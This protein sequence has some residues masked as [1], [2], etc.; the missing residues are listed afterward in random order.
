[1]NNCDHCGGPMKAISAVI[2]QEV[3]V[4]IL[5]HLGLPAR[6]PPIAPSKIPRQE[7]FWDQSTPQY[8]EFSQLLTDQAQL[9]PLF[10]KP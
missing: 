7:D 3:V 1:M 2:K 6:A 9:A 8:D 10:L 4:K 5:T